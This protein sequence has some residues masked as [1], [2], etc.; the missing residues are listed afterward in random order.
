M[1]SGYFSILPQKRK[2]FPHRS[3]AAGDGSSRGGGC[4]AR[5]V[6]EAEV[7]ARRAL[8]HPQL[9]AEECAND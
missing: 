6:E 9:I 5:I 8:P 3:A 1:V 7:A 2:G 4:A